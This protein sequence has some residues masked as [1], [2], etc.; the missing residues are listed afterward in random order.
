MAL[1][2]VFIDKNDKYQYA[3]KSVPSERTP[4]MNRDVVAPNQRPHVKEMKARLELYQVLKI[5]GLIAVAVIAIYALVYLFIFAL[6]I[7]LV[8]FSY[9]NYRG[10]T[11]SKK[12]EEGLL[13][14]TKEGDLN[15]RLETDRGHI[16]QDDSIRFQIALNKLRGALLAIQA[17]TLVLYCFLVPS[18]YQ[19]VN[20]IGFAAITASIFLSV[21]HFKHPHEPALWTQRS[22]QV[23]LLIP[24]CYI[25]LR[26]LGWFSII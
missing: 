17:T 22:L 9:L 24:L 4:H 11:R 16:G 12:W 20:L 1:L 6:S 18:L 8:F 25:V 7:I 13:I 23:I 10:V 3:Q 19:W 26:M 21:Y 5:L 14:F 15:V 2:R